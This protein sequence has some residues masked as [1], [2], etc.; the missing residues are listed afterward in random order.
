MAGVLKELDEVNEELEKLKREFRIKTELYESL[1]NVYDDQLVRI[2]EAKLQI[3]KQA[4]ALNA[5]SEELAEARQLYEEVKSR[6]HEAESKIK[7]ANSANEK[8]Q[9]GCDEKAQKLEGENKKLVS[10]LDEATATTVEFERKLCA[11][12]EKIEVLENLLSDSQRKC[13]EAEQ[14]AQ[15]P[16]ELRQREDA[17]LRLEVQ[18]V[19]I[20]EQLKWK[21]EQFEHLKEAHKRLQDQFQSSKEEWAKEK[22][23]FLE[24]M[25]S[26]HTS[27][28]AQSTINESLQTQLK[29]CNQ[30]LAHEESRRKALEIQLSES[31]RCFEN[32][33]AEC[34]EAET[35]IE[36]LTINRDEE[37]AALRSTLGMKEAL[38]KE[39]EYRIVHLGQENREFLQSIKELQ[40]AQ[41]STRRTDPLLRKLQTKLKDLEL[42]H[43]KCSVTLKEREAEWNIQVE[44]TTE[45]M[46]CYGSDL[47]RLNDQIQQL[48]MQLE[49]CYSSLEVAGEGSSILLMV[50]KS[51]ISEAYSK[52]LNSESQIEACNEMRKEKITLAAEQLEMEHSSPVKAEI[53]LHQAHEQIASLNQKLESFKLLEEQSIV[54]ENELGQHKKMLEESSDCQVRLRERVTLMEAALK[55][56]SNALEKTNSELAVKVCEAG[57]TEAELKIWKSKAESMR[58]CFEQNQE[59]CNQMETSLLAQ[60]ETEQYLRKENENLLCRL[61]DQDQTLNYLQQQIVLLDQ[62]LAKKE[63][64]IEAMKSEARKVHEKE[65]QYAQIIEEGNTKVK[66]LQKV[67]RCLEQESMKRESA[68]IKLGRSEAEKSFKQERD[69]LQIIAAEKD[70]RIEDLQIWALSLEENFTDAATSSFS[71]IV[72]KLVEVDSLKEAFRKAEYLMNLEIQEKNLIIG[73]L[74]EE[75][76]DLHDKLMLQVESLFRSK[77]AAAMEHEALLQNKQ[78]AMENLKDK[79]EKE[80]SNLKK[81]V[82]ELEFTRDATLEKINVLSLERENLLVY[83]EGICEQIG[84]FCGEDIKLGC[85]LSQ[86]SQN[87]EGNDR[88]ALN[89][90]AGENLRHP[91]QECDDIA[92][93]RKEVKGSK[94]GRSPLHELNYYE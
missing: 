51:E 42:V 79:F 65:E 11:C 70:Q 83:A 38:L 5:K 40:E 2:Q 30:A 31:Q 69:K 43:S 10:A 50:L 36:T 23:I 87:S 26:L 80:Q 94:D 64:S 15:A 39:M 59:I 85:M 81:L 27:L 82:K 1:R 29:M 9:S 71:E 72:E 62:K 92:F 45:A 18:S 14:R 41:I 34:Q 75:V 86:M 76:T 67:I 20:Q 58:T 52:L 60:V 91:T 63:E 89:I 66:N 78:R 37:V 49:S 74:Q 61:E 7:H 48:Q 88:L 57:Q 47:K 54:L 53:Y 93:T 73:D 46:N 25:S 28:D 16:K 77:Q 33:L 35:K 56:V 19:N 12:N 90:V 4:W 32:V 17:I 44:R 13:L 84:E 21:K 68:A 6:L 3:E 22:S 24:K 8:L 55:D